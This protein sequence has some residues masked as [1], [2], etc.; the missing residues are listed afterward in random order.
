[1]P[2]GEHFK[3]SIVRDG[4]RRV[5]AVGDLAVHLALVLTGR[6]FDHT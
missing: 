6:K 2:V 4:L 3:Q 1:M 5:T